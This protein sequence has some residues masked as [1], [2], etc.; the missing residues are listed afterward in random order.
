MSAKVLYHIVFVRDDNGSKELFT[1]YPMPID[2][3]Y[4]YRNKRCA[5]HGHGRFLLEEDTPAGRARVY[6]PKRDWERRT[7][8]V[9]LNGNSC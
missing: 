6:K 2:R 1:S 4:D 8:S 7:D 3:A 9:S 5:T